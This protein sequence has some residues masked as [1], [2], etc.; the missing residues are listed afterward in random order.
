MVVLVGHEQVLVPL[1]Y[2]CSQAE[3]LA[4]LAE[5]SLKTTLVAAALGTLSMVQEQPVTDS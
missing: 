4:L 5:R 2:L 1:P 3:G